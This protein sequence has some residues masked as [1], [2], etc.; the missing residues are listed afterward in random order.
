MEVEN[1]APYP[2]SIYW[3]LK[4]D[5]IIPLSGFGEAG[6]RNE[7]VFWYT[8][9]KFKITGQP[10]LFYNARITVNRK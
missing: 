10:A 8:F 3:E 4:A 9:K 1:S 6:S 5:N 2:I 7:N